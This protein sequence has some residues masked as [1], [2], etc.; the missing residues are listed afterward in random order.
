MLWDKASVDTATTQLLA[1]WI[2]VHD[3]H[4][5]V[6]TEEFS[7]KVTEPPAPPEE[8]STDL[9]SSTGIMTERLFEE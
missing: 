6:F 2:G 3:A 9:P 5:V 8:H 1:A 7:W 4:H